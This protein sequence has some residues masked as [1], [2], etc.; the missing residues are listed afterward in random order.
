MN[1]VIFGMILITIIMTPMTLLA[2]EA[3]FRNVNWG[4][5]QGEVEW[6]ESLR[7]ITRDERAITY[8]TTFEGFECMLVYVFHQNALVSGGY[9]FIHT[10]SHPSHYIDDYN[11]LKEMLVKQ[12]GKPL[13]DQTL[14]KDEW[15]KNDPA[16][17]IITGGLE[18]RTIWKKGKTG[19]GLLMFGE[20]SKLKFVLGYYSIEGMSKMNKDGMGGF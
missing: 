2:A 7:V 18:L 4:M 14:W 16:K 12:H 10:R 6:S 20:N 8:H 15:Y 9:Y 17:A 19:F 5:T 1:R 3:D 13:I 11:R